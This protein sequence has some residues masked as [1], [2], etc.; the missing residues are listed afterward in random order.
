MCRE[1]N[2]SPIPPSLSAAEQTGLLERANS[3]QWLYS[4]DWCNRLCQYGWSHEEGRL[5]YSGSFGPSTH[6][7]KYYPNT[8]NFGVVGGS[9]GM[10]FECA[11]RL[12]IFLMLD[13]EDCYGLIPRILVRWFP[14]ECQSRNSIL[15]Q[16]GKHKGFESIK[17]CLT[18]FNV[19][20]TWMCCKNHAIRHDLVL[21]QRP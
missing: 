14:I 8:N 12:G 9:N 2:M 16:V 13:E 10:F 20:R 1:S 7:S 19:N 21:T 11:L 4:F 3:S 15:L 5:W 18:C 6:L 17:F